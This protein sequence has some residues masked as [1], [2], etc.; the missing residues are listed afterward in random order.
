MKVI[1][2]SRVVE[3]SDIGSFFSNRAFRYGDGL[4]E[5]ILWM[6]EGPISLG[7][8]YERLN[9]SMGML[10]MK[11]PEELTRDGL[12]N[13]IRDLV[14]NERFEGAARLRLQVW[15]T[16]GGYYTPSNHQVEYL[17][18]LSPIYFSPYK[19]LDKADFANE[20]HTSYH[21]LSA[22]KSSSALLYVKAGIEKQERNLDEIILTDTRGNVA[23]ASASNIFWVNGDNLFTPSL[24]C[25]CIEGIRRKRVIQHF[26]LTPYEVMEMEASKEHLMKADCIFTTNALGISFIR[27]IESERFLIPG[28]NEF[29]SFLNQILIP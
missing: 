5:T 25:G 4:F 18:E 9:K 20:I 2:N 15:R 14:L 16:A 12:E 11:K 10:G 23:E 19:I 17:I 13:M 7:L 27:S 3:E 24:S 8:H 1:F 6:P 22:L 28:D 29:P 21:E 26:E